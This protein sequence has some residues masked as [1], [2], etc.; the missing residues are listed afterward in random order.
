MMN[1]ANQQMA[2]DVLET[3]GT[4]PRA[5]S[6]K[7]LEDLG[8]DWEQP[9]DVAATFR[10]L[11]GLSTSGGHERRTRLEHCGIAYPVLTEDGEIVWAR[12]GCRDRMCDP[13][14]DRLGRRL[15]H[16]VALKA[17]SCGADVLDIVLTRP[18]VTC[19]CSPRCEPGRPV[20][21]CKEETP[22]QAIAAM[23]KAC[24]KLMQ[25]PV[26]KQRGKKGPP[27]ILPGGVRFLELT[28][29]EA[30][31][32]IG[33]YVVAERGIHAHAHVIAQLGRG[34]TLE[35]AA[36]AIID[37]W[38]EIVGG[39]LAGGQRITLI[40]DA[41]I[42][43]AAAY[44]SKLGDLA[45]LV[46]VAPSYARAVAAAMSGK[47]LAKGWGS[48]RSI[49]KPSKSGCRFADRSISQILKSPGGIV[50]FGDETRDARDI[51]R[52]LMSKPRKLGEENA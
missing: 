18:K 38:T 50:R 52:A 1:V 29:R 31:Q 23:S 43:R 51:A 46:D 44:A 35:A 2:L 45:R 28:A 11:D 4:S 19:A 49:L 32:R 34:W 36:V 48:W 5:E 37:T 3:N 26:A 17:G 22:G 6:E 10:L 9:H 40:D 21:G 24:T 30:G 41:G 13:C 14:G 25:S 47:V 7:A 16:A 12:R 15:A 33:E 39:A 20:E 42:K 27:P 8:L